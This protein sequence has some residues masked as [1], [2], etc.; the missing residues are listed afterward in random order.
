MGHGAVAGY[1]TPYNVNPFSG[2]STVDYNSMTSAA[3]HHTGHHVSMAPVNHQIPQNNYS[4][5]QPYRRTW[6]IGS[7]I[8]N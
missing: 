3:G 8:Y 2:Y 5:V 7:D 4:T 6:G 1:S